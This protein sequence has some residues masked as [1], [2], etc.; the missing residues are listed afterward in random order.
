MLSAAFLRMHLT[1]MLIPLKLVQP[2][3]LVFFGISGNWMTVEVCC[4]F[5]IQSQEVLTD[6]IMG[7]KQMLLIC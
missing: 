1:D 2:K 7:M 4:Y 5:W 6:Q 3:K